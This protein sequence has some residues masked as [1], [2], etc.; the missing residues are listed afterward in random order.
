MSYRIA[1]VLLD[2]F[3]LYG[4]AASSKE[5][6]IVGMHWTLYNGCKKRTTTPKG[7]S[8]V[9]LFLSVGTGRGTRSLLV[10]ILVH[11]SEI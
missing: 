8:D 6:S 10:H 3:F 7:G 2:I 9:V 5:L 1:I 11:I 4:S